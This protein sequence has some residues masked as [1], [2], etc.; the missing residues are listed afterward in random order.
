MLNFYSDAHLCQKPIPIEGYK[1]K[2][3][4]SIQA[5]LKIEWN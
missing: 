1:S 4:I 2:I 5:W 3:L